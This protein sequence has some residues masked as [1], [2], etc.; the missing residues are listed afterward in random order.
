MGLDQQFARRLDHLFDAARRLTTEEARNIKVRR[1]TD[2]QLHTGGTIRAHVSAIEAHASDAVQEALLGLDRR[3]M[4]GRRR[5]E[6]QQ[7]LKARTREYMAGTV[8]TLVPKPR[9]GPAAEAEIARLIDA[10][11]ER[12]VA[13]VDQHATGF[14][15]AAPTSWVQAHPGWAFWIPNILAV[16]ALAVSL[17]AARGDADRVDASSEPEVRGDERH[18]R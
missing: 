17:W 13:S 5:R 10:A 12:L 8:R 9:G 2:N 14:T 16:L 1:A 15:P 7:T 3:H 18:G 6:L 11:T 4:S